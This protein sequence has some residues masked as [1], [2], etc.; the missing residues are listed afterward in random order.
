MSV[1]FFQ[2]AKIKK[3]LEEDPTLIVVPTDVGAAFELS[4]VHG[5]PQDRIKVLACVSVAGE[6]QTEKVLVM[7]KRQYN[8]YLRKE[9]EI[10]EAEEKKGSVAQKKAAGV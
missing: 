4:M 2:A 10:I 7:T 1:G 3:L 5:I 8:Y 6:N 9:T